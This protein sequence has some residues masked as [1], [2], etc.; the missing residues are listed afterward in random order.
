MFKTLNP[1][2][3]LPSN[4]LNDVI[5]FNYIYG[6]IPRE[7]LCMDA[8]AAPHAW[9]LI[10]EEFREYFESR[11]EVDRVDAL[12]D[13]IYVCSG[14]LI[15]CAEKPP[16]QMFEEEMKLGVID[17]NPARVMGGALALGWID[18]IDLAKVFAEIHRSNMEKMCRDSLHAEKTIE[19]YRGTV[20]EDCGFKKVN[21][22]YVCRHNRSGKVLKAFGWSPPRLGEKN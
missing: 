22:Y 16:R 10:L 8:A 9:G 3:Y 2:Y 14:Q 15:R 7:E 4:P 5:R 17:G 19:S 13:I 21:D 6:V 18:G 20:Y 1:K 12:G 11:D